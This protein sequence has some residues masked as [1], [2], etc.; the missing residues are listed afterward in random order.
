MKPPKIVA[1]LIGRGCR[2]QFRPPPR[3]ALASA[4]TKER[5]ETRTLHRLQVR[6]TRPLTFHETERLPC[7]W[8]LAES[9]LAGSTAPAARWDGIFLVGVPDC[10]RN[11]LD[12]L[13]V[14]GSDTLI[15]CVYS[16]P[17]RKK[18]SIAGKDNAEKRWRPDAQQQVRDLR[19][20]DVVLVL[21]SW[22]C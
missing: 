22:V 5:S 2:R 19:I 7:A 20:C 9:V 8:C 3:A 6:W 15:C 14:C 10:N 4:W 11:Q 1:E 18:R 17:A 21:G 16:M 12:S 13:P